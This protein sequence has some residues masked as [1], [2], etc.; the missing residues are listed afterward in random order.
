MAIE[1][2]LRCSSTTPAARNPEVGESERARQESDVLN[3]RTDGSC[4]SIG[5]TDGSTGLGPQ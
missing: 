2:R 4:G 3:G 1:K 5:C